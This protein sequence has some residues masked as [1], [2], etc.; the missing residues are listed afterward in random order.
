MLTL[1]ILDIDD[2]KIS[3]TLTFLGID[4]NVFI[5]ILTRLYWQLLRM[6]TLMSI[7]QKRQFLANFRAIYIRYP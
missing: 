7:P 5:N 3:Q 4:I 6:N 2:P 1:R